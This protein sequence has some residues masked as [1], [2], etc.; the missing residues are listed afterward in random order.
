MADVPSVKALCKIIVDERTGMWTTQVTLMTTYGDRTLSKT[1][2]MT[3]DALSTGMKNAILKAM[4]DVKQ[5]HMMEM[6]GETYRAME[7]AIRMG[8]MIN[9]S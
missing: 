8:E 7:I 2:D 1:F 9:A 6:F 4:E 5:A 3:D